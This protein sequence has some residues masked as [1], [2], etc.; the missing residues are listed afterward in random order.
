MVIHSI[1]VVAVNVEASNK[2]LFVCHSTR[3][4][5]IM[6]CSCEVLSHTM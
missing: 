6:H 4:K 5:V 1:I 3:K 2:A